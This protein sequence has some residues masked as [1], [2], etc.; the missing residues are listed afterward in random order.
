MVS[1]ERRYYP[2]EH[3][4][5]KLTGPLASVEGSLV[6]SNVI[7][8]AAMTCVKEAGDGDAKCVYRAFSSFED[9]VATNFAASAADKEDVEGLR[10]S[11]LA[12][13]SPATAFAAAAVAEE[14][15]AAA[16]AAEGILALVGGEEEQQQQP[17]A[18]AVHPPTHHHPP[19]SRHGD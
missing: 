11:I 9:T 18:G 7:L 12:H 6:N 5:K 16:A 14:G 15:D 10:S 3:V 13:S 17:T 4:T 1:K 8:E 2:R 19:P